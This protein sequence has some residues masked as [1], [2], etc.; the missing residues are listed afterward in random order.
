MKILKLW[1][2]WW[3]TLQKTA[4]SQW[5]GHRATCR[6]L[7][8][9]CLLWSSICKA[10]GTDI[11]IHIDCVHHSVCSMC[12]VHVCVIQYFSSAIH[13]FRSWLWFFEFIFGKHVCGP[14]GLH[15]IDSAVCIGPIC[16]LTGLALWGLT[17]STGTSDIFLQLLGLTSSQC[18]S[19]FF[20]SRASITLPS[21]DAHC[22]VLHKIMTLEH[23]FITQFLSTLLPLSFM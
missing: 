20:Q 15:G 2:L 4:S 21:F 17:Y 13:H 3:P 11:F 7:W 19:H 8:P 22:L 23:I 14:Q 12:M 9:C 5:R 10:P 6:E 16:V 1:L 18:S